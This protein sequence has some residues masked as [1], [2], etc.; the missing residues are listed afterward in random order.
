M[1]LISL[2]IL[3][4]IED[5]L[6][7][8]HGRDPAFRLRDFFDDIAGTSTGAIIAA[9]LM[10][11]RSVQEIRG[12]YLSDGPATAAPGSWSRRIRSCFSRLL[13]RGPLAKTLQREF[14]DLSILHLQEKGIL[15]IDRYLTMVMHNVTGLRTRPRLRPSAQRGCGRDARSQHARPR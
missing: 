13:P 3:K 14:T 7:A 2:G 1:G 15:P 4:R 5:R 9:W 11:R 8:A 10:T 12:I 6:R